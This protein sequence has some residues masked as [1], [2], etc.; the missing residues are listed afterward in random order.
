MN[1]AAAPSQVAPQLQ[2]PPLL[3]YLQGR[4]SYGVYVIGGDHGAVVRH[5][6]IHG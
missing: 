1:P 6:M 4:I 3:D 5:G 2:S